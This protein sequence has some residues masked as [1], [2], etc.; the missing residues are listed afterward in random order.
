M[1]LAAVT[2]TLSDDGFNSAEA[3]FGHRRRLEIVGAIGHFCATV[4][5]ANVVGAEPAMTPPLISDPRRRPENHQIP[6]AILVG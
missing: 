1:I 6:D 4:L 3:A 5:M 2:G